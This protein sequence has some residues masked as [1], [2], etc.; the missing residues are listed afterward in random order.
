MNRTTPAAQS[1]AAA[2]A[3]EPGAGVDERRRR[4]LAEYPRVRAFSAR[5]AAP[6]S[7]EDCAIQ[8]MPDASPTRWHLAHTTWFFETFLLKPRQATLPRTI[9]RAEFLFNS[10]YEA[11]GE[12][13][14]RAKRGLLTRPTVE[15][16]FDRM[17]HPYTKGLLGSMPKLGSKEKLFAIPGQ[18]PDLATLPSGCAFH[19]RC[20]EALESCAAEE[21]PQMQVGRS[22][23]ARCWL[24]RPQADRAEH[25]VIRVASH[26]AS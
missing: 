3:G 6:L 18:P 10:Y 2:E 12:Q 13:F 25:K 23:T 8:S 9:E 15:E 17:R 16:V 1:R 26:A 5:I 20:A 4:L 19:P 24:A 22:W 14:P 7:P 21:P 11:I